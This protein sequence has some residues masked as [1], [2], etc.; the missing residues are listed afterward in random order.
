[1][2]TTAD[3]RS[4]HDEYAD[5]G[6]AL[7]RRLR[8]VQRHIRAWLDETAPVPV[9]VVSACAGDGRD[10]IGVLAD[11]PDAHRV[12][13]T[14]VEADPEIADRAEEQADRVGLESVDV[15]RADAGVSDAFVGAAPADLVL[16]C[17][18]YGNVSDDDVHETVAALPQLCETGA[19]VVW[20]RHRKQPDLTPRIR[21]WFAEQGFDEQCFT[22]PDDAMFAV[23]AHRFL[24]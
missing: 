6:S 13:A 3:W 14:L 11:R 9:T 4:W 23:G 24:G 7:S 18:V 1:M 8:V 15:R 10:L 2:A 22:S 21:G 17:G 12:R 16:M 19:L 20:T 5:P